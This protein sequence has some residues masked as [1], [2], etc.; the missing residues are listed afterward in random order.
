M[1]ALHSENI[2]LCHEVDEAF[3]VIEKPKV[4]VIYS[5]FAPYRSFEATIF[6]NGEHL[7]YQYE[8]DRLNDKE[9]MKQALDL[10]I[11]LRQMQKYAKENGAEDV[12]ID[13]LHLENIRLCQEAEDFFADIIGIEAYVVFSF[14]G[15]SDSFEATISVD[16]H[17]G[18]YQYCVGKL[19]EDTER[20]KA[21]ALNK[22]LKSMMKY[23]EGLKDEKR[24]REAS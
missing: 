20:Q 16:G 23:G 18:D 10:R 14:Y 13:K 2:R 12:K 1:Y 4:T 21:V 5:Y 9:Q 8:A 3:S 24:R 19:N 11:M 6:T 15:A 17:K 7:E 22:K